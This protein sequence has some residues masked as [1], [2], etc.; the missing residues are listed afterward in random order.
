MSTAPEHTEGEYAVASRLWTFILPVTTGKA[1]LVL[2][3]SICQLPNSLQSILLQHILDLLVDAS[4]KHFFIPPRLPSEFDRLHG[5][6]IDAI[7]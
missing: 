3:D 2:L 6:D 5:G 4:K 1:L 7:A